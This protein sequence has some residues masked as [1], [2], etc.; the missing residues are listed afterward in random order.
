MKK[1]NVAIIGQGRSGKNIHGRYYLSERNLYYNVKYVVDMNEHMREVARGLYPGCTVLSDYTELFGKT[2]IDLV[3]NASYSEM[4]FPITKSLLEHGFNVLSEKPFA[5]NVYECDLLI[6]TAKEHGVLLAVFHNT[7]LAPFYLD[8]KEKA[9]SGILGDIKQVSIR[10][11]SLSRRWDWQTLQKKMGGSAYNTGPHPIAMALGFLDFDKDAKVIFTRLDTS[12]T[13][14]DGE[15]YVKILMS[16]PQKP[17]I[18]IEMNSTDAFCDYNIK[19]QG[20]RGTMKL[21]PTTY[22]LKY[23]TEE[24]NPTHSVIEQ[25]LR[26]DD[27]MPVYCSEKLN[28]HEEE[29]TYSATAF[30]AGTA[31]IYE[32]LYYALTEGRPL[33]VNCEMATRVIGVI[34]LAHA[35]NPLPLKVL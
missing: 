19:I 32:N 26:N 18:D 6:E 23:F 33:I 15:D 17:L 22:K 16:A 21:T 30:D 9:G 20:S 5:R 1:L 34:E 12:S 8:A 27:G 35:Q 29:G 10:Y 31:G 3:V 14:G 4:H 28:F 2:D 7:Q 25:T 11:N 24:E 13:S